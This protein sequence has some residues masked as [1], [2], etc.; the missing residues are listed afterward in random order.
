MSRSAQFGD[1]RRQYEPGDWIA[2]EYR[3]LEVFGGAGKSGQGVVYLVEEREAPGPFVL[4]TIQGD[5][6]SAGKSRLVRGAE[7]RGRGSGH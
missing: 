3:V 2:G 6:N 1:V 5:Q 4:K 7:G